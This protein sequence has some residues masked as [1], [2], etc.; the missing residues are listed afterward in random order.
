M[1]LKV[2]SEVIRC[3]NCGYQEDSANPVENPKNWVK[4]VHTGNG[5]ISEYNLCEDCTMVF[6]ATADIEPIENPEE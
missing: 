5:E 1:I 4:I 6:C 3:D 2:S